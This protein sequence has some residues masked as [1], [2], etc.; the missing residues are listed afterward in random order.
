MASKKINL[1]VAD[2]MVDLGKLVLQFAR[3]NRITYHEDDI[4]LESD[5]DHTVL[6]SIIACAFAS[7]YKKS[8]N[9][10]LVAQFALV[11]D[12]VEVYAGDTPHLHGKGIDKRM[13]DKEK[14]EK[15]ALIRIKKEFGKTFPWLH[16]TIEKYEKLDTSEA[17][18]V[19]ILDKA[20]PKITH[21][22]NRVR[23][24][25]KHGYTREMSKVAFEKQILEISKSYGKDQ[26]EALEIMRLLAKKAVLAY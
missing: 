16:K 1:N 5:T 18:F 17:R 3:V 15:K 6:L 22:L 8:L 2:K 10:G 25:K 9:L 23:V 24:L 4:T 14:R 21:S 26:K 13:L 7:D 11:H 19:K 12:L 20:M